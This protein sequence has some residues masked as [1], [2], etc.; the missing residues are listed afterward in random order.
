MKKRKLTLLSV[1]IIV[2]SVTMVVRVSDMV[3]AILHYNTDGATSPKGVAFAES[4]T[5][6]SEN[7]DMYAEAPP[8]TSAPEAKQDVPMQ[9]TD[10]DI[11]RWTDADDTDL[12]LPQLRIEMFKELITRRENLDKRQRILHQREALLR[13]AEQELERKYDELTQLRSEIGALLEQ[14]SEEEQARTRSLVKT[15]EGMKAKDAARIFNTLSIDVLLEVMSSMSE[16]KIAPVIAAMDTERARQV[17]VLLAE[18][19]KLPSLPVQ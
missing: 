15:Y 7:E 5:A 16:R 12:E 3:N 17:T 4:N 13:A 14:Q 2:A 8:E 11:S 6:P 10:E 19:K 18:Q 1:L 9:D